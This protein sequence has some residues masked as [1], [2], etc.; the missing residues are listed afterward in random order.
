MPKEKW[1]CLYCKKSFDDDFEGLQ[2]H[3]DKCLA[4]IQAKNAK[5]AKFKFKVTYSGSLELN[6]DKYISKNGTR[7][8]AAKNKKDAADIVESWFCAKH[9]DNANVD[10][11]EFKAK[12]ILKL[13]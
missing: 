9:I 13:N 1:N 4:S 6:D 3:Q 10:Q 8:I 2:N 5:Q 7:T 11:I 12:T